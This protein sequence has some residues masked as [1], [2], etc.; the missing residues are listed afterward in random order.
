MS[1][2][3]DDD[4]SSAAEQRTGVLAGIAAYALWGGMP[5][6]FHQIQEVLPAEV[7]MHRVVWS[8]VVVAGLLGL[9]GKT[10]WWTVLRTRSAVRVRLAAA[11]ALI[12][13]N[14]LVYVW[15]VSEE[16]VIEAALGYYINPLITVALGV[17]VLREHLARLQ[18]VALGFAL[19]AVA[20]L[21]AAYGR[22]PWIALILACSF[23][24]Y[25]YLKKAVPVPA[26]TSL[27]VETAVL[28]PFAVVGLVVLQVRGD[29]SFLHGSGG[30][31]LLLVALGVV[32]AVPLVLFGTAARR[33]P[34]TLLGLLQ[35]LTPTIQLLCG[36]VVLDED[37]PP[38][39]LA[40][41]VLVWIALVILG[42]DAVRESRRPAELVPVAEAV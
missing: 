33:I 32:T 13:V 18:I 28:L 2:A 12:S 1:T 37:M 41:F 6:V 20:V 23:A 17:V 21:T 25:G 16:H 7:L 15:A 26:T 24:G 31:D 34:L 40:G 38:E 3:P 8:F 30:R 39:R 5:L 35:Y 22:V 27:A 19:A 14:W 42:A 29:A 10:G 4:L 9:R 36:V 11:A